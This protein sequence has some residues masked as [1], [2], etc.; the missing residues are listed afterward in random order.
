MRQAE[1]TY[2]VNNEVVQEPRGGNGKKPNP[3]TLDDQ[4]VRDLGV[5]HRIA[6]EPLWF[7]H[8]YSPNQDCESG[9]DTETKR[10]TPDSPEMVRTKAGI[11]R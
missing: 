11:R 8:V 3:V 5:L 10:N 9:D 6:S 2:G 4:P 7:L 1:E